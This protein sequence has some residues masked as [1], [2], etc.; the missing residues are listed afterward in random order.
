MHLSIFVSVISLELRQSDD[1]S[2]ASAGALTYKGNFVQY[3][4]TTPKDN[5]AQSVYIFR[6]MY[7]ISCYDFLFSFT[8]I[9][10]SLRPSDSYM[11]R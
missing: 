5:K 8:G 9:Y 3:Q 4:I 11:L 1:C 7:F 2:S 10:Y 6:G